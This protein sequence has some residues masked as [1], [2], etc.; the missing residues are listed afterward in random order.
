M[1]LIARMCHAAARATLSAAEPDL[2]AA[3]QC[4]WLALDAGEDA[5]PYIANVELRRRIVSGMPMF[6]E[7][8][9]RLLRGS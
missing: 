3:E 2:E 4:M 9:E 7:E 1:L 6:E 5:A 8:W